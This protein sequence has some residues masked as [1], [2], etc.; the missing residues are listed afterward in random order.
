MTAPA[1][2]RAVC[3]LVVA[4]CLLAAA[5]ARAHAPPY[6]TDIR[7]IGESAATKIVVRTNR[8]LL[9]GDSASRAFRLVCNDAFRAALVE[10]VPTAE[11]PDGG[12]L[13][14]TYAA[15]LLRSDP[16]FCD[17]EPVGPEGMSPIDV[18]SDL[19]GNARAL[20]LPLDGS[21]GSLFE[22]NDGAASFRALSPVGTA[23]TAYVS[24]PSN[25]QR[26]YVSTNTTSGNSSTGHV[27]SSDD[28]GKQFTDR[29]IELDGSELRAFVLAVDPEDSERVFVRTQ[30]RDG[31]T[32]E[33]LLRSEDGGQTFQ[34]VLHAEGPLTVALAGGGT[35]WAG[36]ATGLYRS[37]DSGATFAPS[38][39]NGLVR[40]SCLAVRAGE[41]YAC[42]LNELEF[43][44]LVSKDDGA[45]FDWFLRFSQVTARA[46]CSPTSDE[47]ARCAAAFEDWSLEQLVPAGDGGAGSFGGGELPS[48]E[49][50][51][52]EPGGG[53]RMGK[54]GKRT[55][56]LWFL[57]LLGLARYRRRARA[58]H[59]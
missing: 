48:A 41:L 32:P 31:L 15:G 6:A 55:S 47:G 44:V 22:S 45:T 14:G 12:L 19:E 16:T 29:V 10:V 42:A 34:T 36:S 46:E 37:R 35:V 54:P 40:I 52:D 4:V 2:S 24:A 18:K 53:C 57:A 56:G 8:G 13:V 43:G 27:L 25:S 58:A 39:D 20:L 3:A 59:A 30:S 28:G 26:V 7:W 51:R 38:T 1:Y 9:V 33:R 50:P 23:P 49:T 21:D 5:P 17:F 11:L